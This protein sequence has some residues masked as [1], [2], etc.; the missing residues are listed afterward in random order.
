MRSWC[1]MMLV[2]LAG[3]SSSTEA[4]RVPVYGRVL[5][6]GYPL[7]SGAIVFTPDRL[8]GSQGPTIRADLGGDG[9]FVI[10][11][12]GLPPGWYRITVASLDV[13]LPVRLRDPET[14]GI[15]REVVAGRE[16]GFDI[17]LSDQVAT[18]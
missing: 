3:C 11:S 7:R 12:G 2:L 13:S 10:S 15:V 5:M 6:H 18:R 1:A 17:E 14:A 4:P 16:N 8:H 9:K